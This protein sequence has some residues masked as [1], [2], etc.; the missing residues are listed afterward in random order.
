MLT[1]AIITLK[2]RE[3]FG[4]RAARSLGTCVECGCSQLR[5]PSHRVQVTGLSLISSL[6]YLAF[7][8]SPVSL[9]RM[10]QPLAIGRMEALR[11]ETKFRLFSSHN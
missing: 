10:F 2:L 9:L 5:K 8:V 3:W 11:V 1:E 6:V 7:V 4:V